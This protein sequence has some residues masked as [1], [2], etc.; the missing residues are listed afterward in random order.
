[1]IAALVYVSC[2]LVALACSVL[3]LRG[4]RNSGARLLFWSGLCFAG[5]TVTNVIV[6]V[7]L[8]LV[9]ELDLS[10]WRNLT[11]LVGVGFLVFGLVRDGR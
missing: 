1:M 7:D 6:F 3:L 5:L 4:H 8:V 9:P 2:A 10:L 11:T